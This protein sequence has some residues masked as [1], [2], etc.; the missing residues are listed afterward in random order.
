MRRSPGGAGRSADVC[1]AR[2]HQRTKASLNSWW[3][4]WPLFL[5]FFLVRRSASRGAEG[6]RS[7][8]T[9]V[10]GRR[11]IRRGV[12][13]E[14]SCGRFYRSECCGWSSRCGSRSGSADAQP[15]PSH[16]FR[17]HPTS[18]EAF[19]RADRTTL[20]SRPRRGPQ[21]GR[22]PNLQKPLRCS[23]RS[24]P[25]SF[26][27]CWWSSSPP[28]GE[29]PISDSSLLSDREGHRESLSG[30]NVDLTED[31]GLTRRYSPPRTRVKR[32]A[33]TAGRAPCL[34]PCYERRETSFDR[35]RRSS[36]HS[37]RSDPRMTSMS[38]SPGS[39]GRR[40]QRAAGAESLRGLGA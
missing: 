34:L 20:C 1:R 6:Q 39:D 24:C 5:F 16:R 33:S 10:R 21:Q 3:F 4:L 25:F 35:V 23:Y 38:R 11:L 12:G 26:S 29:R 15:P 32:R 27:R 22:G 14:A 30:R 19:V 40:R 36:S 17:R 7:P 31:V 18:S 8:G 37:G 2:R 28:P 9:P 13:A